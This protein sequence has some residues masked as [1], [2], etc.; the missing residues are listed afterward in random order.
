MWMDKRDCKTLHDSIALS[1]ALIRRIERRIRQRLRWR[2]WQN[3]K[4]R[5]SLDD[6]IFLPHAPKEIEERILEAL[7]AHKVHVYRMQTD[8]I[9][10]KLKRAEARRFE[11]YMFFHDGR[12][13]Q[14]YM[15]APF[16]WLRKL[17]GRT[18]FE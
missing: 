7:A 13:F 9:Y 14:R 3:K 12:T 2:A 18:A 10:A 4:A 1:D 15:T 16:R 11:V 17:I 6:L 5:V 8:P